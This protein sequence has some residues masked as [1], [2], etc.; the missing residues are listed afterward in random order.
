MNIILY[1][2]GMF[3]LYLPPL[4]VWYFSDITNKIINKF[5]LKIIFS[6]SIVL[7]AIMIQLMPT[8]APFVFMF[9]LTTFNLILLLYNKLFKNKGE[10]FRISIYVCFAISVLWEWPIQLT[11]YQNPIAVILSIFKALGIPFLLITLVK[12]GLK[13]NHKQSLLL[14]Y[15]VL[16]GI[17]LTYFLTIYPVTELYYILHLYRIFWLIL[18]IFIIM[19]TYNYHKR[20]TKPEY[21]RK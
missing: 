11:N 13:I 5:P 1:I 15:N 21:N 8:V 7:W 6:I 18:F 19:E 2:L 4:T 16:V 9:Y 12:R 14:L 17:M 3:L 20:Q 10:A